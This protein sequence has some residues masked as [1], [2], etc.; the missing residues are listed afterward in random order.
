MKPDLLCIGE[1]LI[2][3]ACTD[4]GQD[5]AEGR[6][7]ERNA[8]GAPANAA[9]AAARL[10]TA[11]GFIG[12]VGR[13]PF[14]RYLKNTLG[15]YGV[16]TGGLLE[17]D[18]APT[19]LAF[20]SLQDDGERDFVF[21]RGADEELRYAE[22]PQELLKSA[23]LLH[24]GSATA[25][26]GGPLGETYRR[27]FET[28]GEGRFTSFDPNYRGD[29]WRGREEEF[30]RRALP[31]AAGADFMKLSGEELQLLS[32][33]GDPAAG[34][35]ELHGRGCPVIAVTLG[36]DGTYLSTPER[37]ERIPTVQ[38]KALDATGAGDAFI[39]AVLSRVSRLKDLGGGLGFDQWRQFIRFANRVGALVTTRVG[40]LSAL[41]TEEAVEERFG[42]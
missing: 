28:A 8:G 38:V 27:L 41:P 34:C 22:I 6:H 9:A 40:A 11:T 33:T 35:R 15:E 31:Y 1:L 7:F 29:L 25:L 19:T 21:N 24:F 30:V 20:V 39:G 12:K 18:T 13:D 16:D 36:A 4:R 42:P 5:L 23:R 3:F 10:G 2:D 26:L 37:Q 14:G 17:S 32:G